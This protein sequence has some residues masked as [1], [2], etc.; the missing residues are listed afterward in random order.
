MQN[1]VHVQ[2]FALAHEIESEITR[3]QP[4]KLFLPSVKP[5]ER[6]SRVGEIFRTDAG[7]RFEHIELGQLIELFELTHR[8]SGEG[9]LIHGRVP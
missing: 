2:R 1:I 3:A 6:L 4:V 5:P 7:Y 9:D 8:L